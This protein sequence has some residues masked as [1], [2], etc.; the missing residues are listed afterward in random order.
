MK[1]RR[2]KIYQVHESKEGFVKCPSCGIRF[3][4][5]SASSW[6]GER[7]LKCKARLVLP[8]GIDLSNPGF[9]PPPLSHSDHPLLS[10]A[11][12]VDAH[13]QGE[14]DRLLGRI[15]DK[16]YRKDK[17]A[18]QRF[19]LSALPYFL[20]PIVATII[21]MIVLNNDY[22]VLYVILSFFVGALAITLAAAYTGGRRFHCLT[23]HQ[24]MQKIVSIYSSG[25][26]NYSSRTTYRYCDRCQ[27]YFSGTTTK[28]HK[29]S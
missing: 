18:S 25:S 3:P 20:V 4:I 7:H 21:A 26:T 13:S 12:A 11:T 9:V 15:H 10:T 8:E 17:G 2:D 14:L 19:F 27:L 29:Q 24:P 5:Y 23:C 1:F 28:G 16:S 22:H 6:D